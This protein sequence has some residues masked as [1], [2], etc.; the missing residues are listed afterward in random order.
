MEGLSEVQETRYEEPTVLLVQQI[1]GEEDIAEVKGSPTAKSNCRCLIVNKCRME[2]THNEWYNA[3]MPSQREE[4]VFC[5]SGC[6]CAVCF[7]GYHCT[8]KC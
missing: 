4:L 3:F 1:G 8:N 7:Q 5:V 2:T 6:C